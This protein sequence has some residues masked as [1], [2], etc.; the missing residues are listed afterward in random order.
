MAI[1]LGM[2]EQGAK[3]NTQKQLKSTLQISGS[4]KNIANNF[5]KSIKAL[6]KAKGDSKLNIANQIYVMK[7]NEIDPNFRNVAVKKFISGV[8]SVNF[9]Q[10]VNAAKKINKWVGENTNGKIKDLLSPDVL[11]AA[12]QM[13]LVN[14][15]YFNGL[16]KY[17]FNKDDTTEGRFYINNL[18][19]TTIK[20]MHGK[21]QYNYG[22]IVELGA[23]LLE[24]S[25]SNS[26]ISFLIIL[27]D[28]RNG[29]V[30]L[31]QKLASY[32][33]SKI[34]QSMKFVEVELTIPTFTSKYKVDLVQILQKVF[35]ILLIKSISDN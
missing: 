18:D 4:N 10:N 13:V 2:V 5:Y 23:T 8:Q 27:P 28:Q 14:A 17:P 34:D 16:W 31:E 32:D 3:C 25:Y 22:K 11:S 15:I 21:N 29:L 6:N 30:D 24:I 20:F 9:A 19:F 12:T 26:D 35:T 1:V 33:L 7:G